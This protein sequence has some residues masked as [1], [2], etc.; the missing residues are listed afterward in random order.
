MDVDEYQVEAARTARMDRPAEVV[1]MTFG[2]GIAGEAGEVAD[3]VK[4]AYG[5]GAG[6][7]IERLRLELGD[8]AW[9]LAAVATCHGLRLSDVLAANI[10]KLRRRYPDGFSTA[11]SIARADEGSTGDGQVG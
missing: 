6:M 9:Y 3:L 10:R 5:H 11:A 8:V 4:K 2:L 7:D 1:A